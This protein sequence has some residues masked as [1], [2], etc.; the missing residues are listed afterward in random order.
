MQQPGDAPRAMSTEGYDAGWRVWSDMIRYHPGSRHRRRLIRACLRGLRPGRVLDVGC[1]DGQLLDELRAVLRPP[2]DLAGADLSPE[3]VARA[4]RRL[5]GCA[6]HVLDLAR[7]AL[8]GTWDLVVCS[9][10]L[11]HL[12]DR[13]AGFDHLRAIVAP[14][15]HLLVTSPTGP[16][17]ETE[18]RW[19]HVT[20]PTPGEMEAHAARTGL[21]VRQA[22]CWGWPLYSLLKLA[23]NVRPD[24]SVAHFA[25]GA[26]GWR[27]RAV[28]HATYLA[29]FLNLR[30]SPRGVQLVYLFEA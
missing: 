14:G 8:P 28:A 27:Q 1:G 7:A 26:Y 18:R 4:E 21:R 20:H 16:V 9:E 12:E 11:E 17:Y 15:G 25:S 13:A 22:W 3:V 5:P 19:G 29:N 24:W 6:F 30:S 23:T 10:V 2:V